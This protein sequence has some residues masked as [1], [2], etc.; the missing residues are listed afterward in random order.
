MDA[1]GFGFGRDDFRLQHDAVEAACIEFL[2]N[3]DEIAVGARHQAIEQFDDIDARTERRIDRR[4]FEPD[5]A[6]ADDEHLLRDL[7]EFERSG[8]I[9][10]ARIGRHER[11]RR[12]FRAG[13]DDGFFETNDLLAA[14]SPRHAN[15]AD[16]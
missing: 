5:D 7:P 3:P 8:R 9:D 14:I 15:D 11:Q 1:I 2:P 12:R 4:H 16:R 6:A 10:D 13:S